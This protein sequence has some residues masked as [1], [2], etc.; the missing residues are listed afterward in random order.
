MQQWNQEQRAAADVRARLRQQVAQF[1]GGVVCP[2]DVKVCIKC[3]CVALSVCRAQLLA[4]QLLC[5][6]C[7]EVVFSTSW[8]WF[9]TLPQSINFGPFRRVGGGGDCSAARCKPVRCAGSAIPVVVGPRASE[10]AGWLVGLCLP[11]LLFPCPLSL[12]VC[13]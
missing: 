1:C 7:G 2:C 8:C 13:T 12:H 4:W 5:V 11:F 6:V 3:V 9:Y 10:L